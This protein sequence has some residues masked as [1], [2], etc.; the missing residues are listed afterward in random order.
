MEGDRE[1]MN[2]PKCNLCG[3]KVDIFYELEKYPVY[4]LKVKAIIDKDESKW[5]KYLPGFKN[6][7]ILPYKF[8]E[9]LSKK[10]VVVISSELFQDEI[11]KDLQRYVNKGVKIVKLY[12]HCEY[13][14][15]R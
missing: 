14:S 2:Q 3:Q 1:I 4:A 6:I 10:D 7:P 13:V 15:V 9:N 5:G 11:V 8:L 12:P